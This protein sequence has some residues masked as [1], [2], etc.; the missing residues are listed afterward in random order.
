MAAELIIN[1]NKQRFQFLDGFRGLIWLIVFLAHC[2]MF[3]NRV[4]L[5]PGPGPGPRTKTRTK[6]RLKRGPGPVPRYKIR[7]RTEDPFHFFPKINR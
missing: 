7:T 1:E 5:K 4:R 2:N 3:F 6:T